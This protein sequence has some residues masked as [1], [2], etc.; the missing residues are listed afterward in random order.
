MADSR[1][2]RKSVTNDQMTRFLIHMYSV[3]KRIDFCYGHRL[4]DY[5]GVCKHPH[6]HNAIAEI[7]V[8]T[9]ARPP[10]HGVRLQRHQADCQRLDRSR[11]RSQDAAA[12][13]RSAGGAAAAAGRADFSGRQQSD[14]RADRP[15]D[16]RLR[17]QQGLP[18]VRVTV[19]ETPTSFAEY[20]PSRS[21]P[22]ARSPVFVLVL[23]SSTSTGPWS[24]RGGIWRSPPT[25]CWCSAAASPFRSGN[26]PYG[27]GRR[28]DA[29]ARARSRR[30]VCSSRLTRSIVFSPSTT[31]GCWRSP[32]L[33][34]HPRR[35]RLRSRRHDARGLTNKPLESTRP[36]LD[37][38]ELARHFSERRGAWW[39]RSAAEKAGS[40]RFSWLIAR[41]RGYTGDDDP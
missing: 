9:D 16:F 4:L 39:R 13:R 11:A 12:A 23:S 7:E 30:R 5:D 24:I 18:V 25:R 31:A 27:R 32:G 34:G 28:G 20:E 1:T 10:Q 36:I 22:S 26:R 14:G 2:I 3:T 33:R 40:G 8:R 29:R 17:A 35:A 21:L 6:G 41:R 19:W 37:R 38:F 15:P